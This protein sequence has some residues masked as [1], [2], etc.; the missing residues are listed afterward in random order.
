MKLVRTAR[1]RAEFKPLVATRKAQA[2]VMVLPPGGASDDALSNEHP[3]CEQW[4]YVTSGVGTA[5]VISRRG[6]RRTVKIRK[7]DLLVIESR[8]PHQI[9]NHGRRPLMT[10]SF[11]MPPAYRADGQLRRPYAST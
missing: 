10:L 11:Y 3:Q 8:E 5:T 7:G 2:A 9:R 4:L 1:H 6:S